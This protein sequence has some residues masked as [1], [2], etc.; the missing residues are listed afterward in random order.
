MEKEDFLCKE[1]LNKL[2]KLYN[3]IFDK[4]GYLKPEFYFTDEEIQALLHESNGINSNEYSKL[5][6]L[7]YN[8][9]CNKYTYQCQEIIDR[10][11]KI[12][13]EIHKCHEIIN[14]YIDNP[15]FE[16]LNVEFE[17]IGYRLS[18]PTKT[19]SLNLS[20]PNKGIT[21]CHVKCF[22]ND[23]SPIQFQGNITIKK[24]AK[25][26]N[27]G[28]T[29]KEIEQEEKI[30]YDLVQVNNKEIIDI[31]LIAEQRMQKILNKYQLMIE[32]KSNF[33]KF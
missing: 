7:F 1:P 3:T 4:S 25:V 14:N 11:Y 2:Q 8:I 19:I 6:F 5:K 28:E 23:S 13:H 32:E 27:L 30:S 16:E 17:T 9:V 20:I 21:E 29:E 24:N 31:L 26:D 22:I 18:L 33:K 10:I 15:C 12:C